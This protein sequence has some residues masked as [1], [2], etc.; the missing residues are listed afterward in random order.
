MLH[1]R[2]NSD[3]LSAAVFESNNGVK[4]PMRGLVRS[5]CQTTRPDSSA[6]TRSSKFACVAVD[7]CAT[8]SAHAM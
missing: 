5:R 8:R 2:E 7:A 1:C 3:Q 4:L 6:R